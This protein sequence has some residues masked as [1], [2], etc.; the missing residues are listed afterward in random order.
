M[1]SF[2]LFYG[3]SSSLPFAFLLAPSLVVSDPIFVLT[4]IVLIPLLMPHHSQLQ[5][6]KAQISSKKQTMERRGE[7]SHLESHQNRTGSNHLYVGVLFSKEDHQKEVQNDFQQ[8]DF[9]R[10]IYSFEAISCRSFR[11]TLFP[12]Q[13]V[14]VLLLKILWL[15]G[16]MAADERFFVPPDID[17]S[18]DEVNRGNE[19]Y[20]RH[21]VDIA[22]MCWDHHEKSSK[23]KRFGKAAKET[24]YIE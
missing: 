6:L 3:G 16:K 20:I 5:A 17:A 1:E 23:M 7:G 14:A 15:P 4:S 9:V 19:F 21:L 22:Q 13:V 18:S 2:F 10:F 12:K 8:L 11:T 24:L